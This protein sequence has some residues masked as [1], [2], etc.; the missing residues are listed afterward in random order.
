M[1]YSREAAARLAAE[2][3]ARNILR[4]SI[5]ANYTLKGLVIAR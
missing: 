1:D 2:I 4:I 5:T 3:C